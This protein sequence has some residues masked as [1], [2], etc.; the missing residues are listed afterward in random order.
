M[1]EIQKQIDSLLAKAEAVRKAEKSQVIERMKAAIEVY[2][3]TPEDL[4]GKTVKQ[5]MK[6][7]GKSKVG[8]VKYRDE[9][10]NTWTGRGPKPRWLRDA[11]AK[12]R[13]LESFRT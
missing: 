1:L 11:L 4:F 6:L 3:I 9:E 7:N 2:H 5:A 13:A 8:V 12:G 10:G